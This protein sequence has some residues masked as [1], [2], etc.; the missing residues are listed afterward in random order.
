LL[1]LACSYHIET[2]RDEAEFY[3]SMV[4]NRSRAE[5][6]ASWARM[7]ASLLTSGTHQRT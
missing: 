2:P 7:R 6:I 3:V 4:G 5:V 1:E